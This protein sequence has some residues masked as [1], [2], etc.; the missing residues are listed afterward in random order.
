MPILDNDFTLTAD[1]PEARRRAA[2][3][4]DR[5]GMQLTANDATTAATVVLQGSINGDVWADLATATLKDPLVGG[6][7]TTKSPVVRYLRVVARTLTGDG[8]Q[9]TAHVVAK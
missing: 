5:F 7:G 9:V 2:V 4:A 6:G 8:A 3:G 1:A